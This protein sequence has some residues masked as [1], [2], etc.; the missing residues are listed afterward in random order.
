MQ[1]K[2]LFVTDRHKIIMII[3]KFLVNKSSEG[4]VHSRGHAC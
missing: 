1:L 4:G 3:D 2:W